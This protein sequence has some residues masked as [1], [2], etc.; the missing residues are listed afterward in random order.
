MAFITRAPDND[1]LDLSSLGLVNENGQFTAAGGVFN[2]FI[3]IANYDD[4]FD[5]DL[6][7]PFVT[8]E[9]CF[10]TIETD[11]IT[12]ERFYQECDEGDE[13]AQLIDVESL[14]PLAVLE[15]L[16]M[17][18]LASDFEMYAGLLPEDGGL[19][20]K[21]IAQAIDALIDGD[22]ID[23]KGPF[24]KGAF[25]RMAK[26]PKGHFQVKRMLGAMIA[27]GVIKRAGANKPGDLRKNK[28][29]FDKQRPKGGYKR[30]T[31]YAKGDYEKHPAGGWPGGKSG[32][33]RSQYL[34][35][36][37]KHTA[38]R[39][40]AA[41]KAGRGAE[42]N[43]GEKGKTSKLA[44]GRPAVHT[45]KARMAKKGRAAL[46]ESLDELKASGML[47]VLDNTNTNYSEK[48]D[49]GDT[50]TNESVSDERSV[51]NVF[52]ASVEALQATIG[53]KSE[54]K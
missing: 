44:K 28:T 53:K 1:E 39:K 5:D 20:E 22:E 15:S 23:E 42:F 46:K 38:Q 9:E 34:A 29:G 49:A 14:H 30:G 40:R 13:G 32:A 11:P 8:V 25:R 2:N 10:A 18:E 35:F 41:T 36:R 19:E 17:D 43:A 7:K 12:G 48:P 33:R 31:G 51:S 21:A 6:L 37:S 47:D 3:S 45:I 52:G 16:D 24:K 27:K 26:S 50:A 4:L 54:H